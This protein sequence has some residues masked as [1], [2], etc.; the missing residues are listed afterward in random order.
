[1]HQERYL[2]GGEL[3][4]WGVVRIQIRFSYI[5]Q[6]SIFTVK[7]EIELKGIF[8]FH[9]SQQKAE[10]HTELHK[11]NTSESIK[12]LHATCTIIH[13]IHVHRL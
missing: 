8:Y 11:Y 13:K 4:W 12:T 5:V 6:H 1:M 10:L 3:S 7:K 9:I 2:H